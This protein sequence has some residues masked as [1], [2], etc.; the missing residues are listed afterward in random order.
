MGIKGACLDHNKYWNRDNT[1]GQRELPP[2]HRYHGYYCYQHYRDGYFDQRHLA[3]VSFPGRYH[4]HY[5]IASSMKF[6]GEG[7]GDMITCRF[8]ECRHTGGWCPKIITIPVL[9]PLIR[10]RHCEQQTV[11][12]RMLRH[13]TS[14]RQ[15]KTG[16]QDPSLGTAL[17]VSTICLPDGT[18]HD[19]IICLPDGTAHDQ[20]ICLPDGT[21]HD[22]IICLPDGT[23]HDQI[24]Q[25][26]PHYITVGEQIYTGGGNG[27]GTRLICH[28][29]S[30][31]L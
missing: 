28:H 8:T 25:A 10:P 21:A 26:F 11:T 29:L 1:T 4:H 15:Y 16:R 5:L 17:R 2:F 3:L 14:D 19:Q 31:T 24:S 18:A 6:G 20:I 23:A 13:P 9:F 22:Q 7:L 27:L 12:S 30:D